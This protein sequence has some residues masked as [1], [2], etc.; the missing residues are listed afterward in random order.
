MIEDS[1]TW[2]LGTVGNGT[3]YK[4]AKYAD[5]TGNTVTSSTTIAKVGLLRLGELGAGQFERSVNNINYWLLT[6]YSSSNVRYV[7]YIGNAFSINSTNAI[8]VR[9][10]LNLKSNVVITSGDGTKIN[11]FQLSV[12]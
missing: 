1:T 11:P 7:S 2:Y 12:Q 4:L 10:S 5:T 8:D 6:P 3:S 9:P